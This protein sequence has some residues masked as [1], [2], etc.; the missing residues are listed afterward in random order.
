MKKLCISLCVMATGL[1]AAPPAYAHVLIPDETNTSGAIVHIM[2]DDD[3]IAGQ[4]ATLFFDMQ[5]QQDDESTQVN[6]VIRDANGKDTKVDIRTDGSSA[7]A[8]HTFPSRGTY[9]LIFTVKTDAKT[10]TFKQSQRVTRG[11]AASALDQPTYA[12]AEM[13]LLAG[14]LGFLVVGIVAFNRR[15]EIARQSKW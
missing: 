13:L 15:N 7:T 3:P 9:E 1:V 10:Y 4:P 8:R 6:L 12:W 11:E 14:C 2:P 5:D